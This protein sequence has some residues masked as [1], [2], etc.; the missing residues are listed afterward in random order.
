MESKSSTWSLTLSA[1]SFSARTHY[2]C[3]I[4]S[5]EMAGIYGAL[6][7]LKYGE[8]SDVN[9]GITYSTTSS[10]AER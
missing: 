7:R 9:Y 6:V 10:I 2:A 1:V 5:T 4:Y 3:R 8:A